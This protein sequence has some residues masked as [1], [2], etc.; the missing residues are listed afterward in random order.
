MKTIKWTI[1]EG[2]RKLSLKC[3][4][5]NVFFIHLDGEEL[6]NT[7]SKEEAEYYFEEFKFNDLLDN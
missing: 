4:S 7:L 1:L 5:E 3:S 6:H 2:D